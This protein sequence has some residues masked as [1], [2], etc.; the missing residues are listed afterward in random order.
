MSF[1][2]GLFRPVVA[3]RDVAQ[4]VAPTQLRDFLRIRRAV[5]V[6]TVAAEHG[7]SSRTGLDHGQSLPA[8]P[9][10]RHSFNAQ[11]QKGSAF[12]RQAST[13][14]SRCRAFASLRAATKLH[15]PRRVT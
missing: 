8:A 14:F 4:T 3:F 9:L 15:P 1:M 10:Q 11:R 6:G 7:A 12:P 2:D 13:V 5:E